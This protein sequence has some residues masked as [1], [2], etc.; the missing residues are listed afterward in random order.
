MIRINKFTNSMKK[1][2]FL[3]LYVNFYITLKQT[4]IIK[5]KESRGYFK[6]HHSGISMIQK[7]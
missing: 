7:N 6:Q 3:D 1:I 4:L 2:I 5:K